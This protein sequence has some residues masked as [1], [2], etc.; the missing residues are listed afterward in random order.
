MQTPKP[1]SLGL[2]QFRRANR[3]TAEIDEPGP[4]FV[5]FGRSP[6][7]CDDR[8]RSGKFHRP[9]RFH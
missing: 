9:I 5:V 7:N 2:L 1:V 8:I 4:E 3:D 6:G